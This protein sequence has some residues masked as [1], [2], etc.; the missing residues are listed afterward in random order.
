MIKVP[1]LFHYASNKAVPWNYTNQV[2]LQEPQAI[3]VSLEMKQDPSVNDIVGSSGL[4]R[5]GQCYVPGLSRV[6][7]EGERIEQN[8]IEVTILKKKGKEPLNEPISEAKANEFLKFI[9]HNEYNIV[10]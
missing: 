9:K 10:E 4:T 7:E 2:I 8:D 3:Q 1:T 6:K 5:S